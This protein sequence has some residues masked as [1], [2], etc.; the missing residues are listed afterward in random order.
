M[1]ACVCVWCVCVVCVWCVCVCG[2]GKERG[3]GLEEVSLYTHL[4]LLILTSL[5]PV[6][7]GNEAII[8]IFMFGVLL[9]YSIPVSLEN[10]DIATAFAGHQ[11]YTY[12]LYI[13]SEFH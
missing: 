6:G 1:C 5:V 9:L 4:Q 13:L 11:S 2:W 7:P 12:Q 10:L 8:L 3:K